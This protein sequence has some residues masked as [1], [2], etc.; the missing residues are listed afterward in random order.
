MRTNIA[1]AGNMKKTLRENTKEKDKTQYILS[2]RHY[3]GKNKMA[4]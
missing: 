1:E 3:K 2:I 4:P